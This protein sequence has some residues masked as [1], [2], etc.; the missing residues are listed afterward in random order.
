MLLGKGGRAKVICAAT[1]KS[2]AWVGNDWLAERLAMGHG[3]YVSG[4]VNRIRRDKKE[5]KTLKRDEKIWKI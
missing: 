3:S 2:H 1:A 4:L 5:Q